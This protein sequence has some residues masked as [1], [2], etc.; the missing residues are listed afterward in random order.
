M[1]RERKRQKEAKRK[2]DMEDSRLSTNLGY[3]KGI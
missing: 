3:K 2:E 1:S